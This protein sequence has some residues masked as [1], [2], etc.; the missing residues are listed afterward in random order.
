MANPFGTREEIEAE[1]YQSP[2][3]DLFGRAWNRYREAQEAHR[4][5]RTTRSE[6]EQRWT[7]TAAAADVSTDLL[8][9][10]PP[11]LDEIDLVSAMNAHRWRSGE[12]HR[13]PM[14][15]MEQVLRRRDGALRQQPRTNPIDEQTSRPPPLTSEEMTISVACKICYEQKVD[16]LLEPCM[17][18][19][20]CHWCSELVRERA[21]RRRTYD[22]P[23]RLNNDEDKWKCPICRHDVVQ[24]RRVYLG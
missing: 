14:L 20:I 5:G 6:E 23:P 9:T 10:A 19:A 13:G 7:T 21:R 22:L 16:T 2:V 1:G 8:G 15:A 17:H 24:A 4:S 11:Q 12:D 18:I 3:A